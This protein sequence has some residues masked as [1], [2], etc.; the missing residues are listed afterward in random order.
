MAQEAP[1]GRWVPDRLLEQPTK[2]LQ[3][4][5]RSSPQPEEPWA[6]EPGTRCTAA[7]PSRRSPPR[8]GN[9]ITLSAALTPN[10]EWEPRVPTRPVQLPWG[11]RRP[12]LLNEGL[13][14][15][16]A[17]VSSMTVDAV[18]FPPH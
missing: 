3:S 15:V 1:A 7:P 18:L 16:L 12:H 4:R 14:T 17:Q 11:P 13:P 10:P 5:A 9:P 2:A 8:R 6:G